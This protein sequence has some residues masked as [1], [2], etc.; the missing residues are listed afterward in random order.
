[1]HTVGQEHLST[2]KQ[3]GPQTPMGSNLGTIE[4]SKK[5]KIVIAVGY[6]TMIFK[7]PHNTQ[8]FF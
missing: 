4:A 1:M 5:K 2:R 7:N 3:G 6:N 8:F